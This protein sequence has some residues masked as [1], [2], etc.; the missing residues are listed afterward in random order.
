MA[1]GP[2]RLFVALITLFAPAVSAVP[3]LNG[4]GG[5]SGYGIST[6]CLHPNDN[7]SYAGVQPG[8]AATPTPVD[9][10]QAFPNGLNLFGA[11]WREFYLNTNGNITFAA[12]LASPNAVAFPVEGQPMVAP[13][14]ADVDTRGGGQPSDNTICYHLE[15]NRLVVTWHNVQRHG[16]N[17]GLRNDFQMILSTSFGCYTPDGRGD[18]D[19]EFRYRRC[20][21]AAGEGD[22]GLPGTAAQVGFDAGNRRNYV[23]LPMS[24]SAAIADVCT[25]SN[26]PGGPPGLFRFQIRSSG[27]GPDYSG[28]G[29]PCTVPGLLGVC[30]MGRTSATGMINTCAQVERPRAPRCNG[31]DNDC[32]GRI[33]D[34]A[35]LCASGQVCDQGL[36]RER[37]AGDAECAVGHTCS[38]RGTCVETT[39]LEVSCPTGQRCQR[40]EC[41]SAC[42]GVTCPRGQQCRAGRCSDPCAGV[43][44]GGNEVCEDHAKLSTA[45]QCIT[46]CQCRP[47]NA[48]QVCAPDG[49]CIDEGC[50]DATCPT[51]AVCEQGAC[52]DRCASPSGARLCL[53]DEVCRAGQCSAARDADSGVTTVDGGAHAPVTIEPTGCGCRV[54]TTGSWPMGGTLALLLRRRRRVRRQPSIASHSIARCQ[55]AASARSPTTRSR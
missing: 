35:A 46:G 9:L 23:A 44:C 55:P 15:P 18:P 40:G 4:F 7:G 47:C 27:W 41:V 29:Q 53:E 34:D 10:R 1:S 14:W 31:L 2:E 19:I 5:P 50:R 20:E 26:V 43:V 54:G 48:G 25:T 6:H 32:D 52:V 12:P 13:W 33:D 42:D 21:W 16:A 24:R 36:C 28:A 22:D 8:T 3:L 39:C 11:P 37:C 51:G 38:P 45:G 49:R 30:A 17:D